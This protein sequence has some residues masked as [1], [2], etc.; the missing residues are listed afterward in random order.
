VNVLGRVATY[1]P[2]LSEHT[3]KTVQATL[4][5]ILLAI[6]IFVCAGFAGAKLGTSLGEP[7]YRELEPAQATTASLAPAQ[8]VQKP[9]ELDQALNTPHNEWSN[10]KVGSGQSYIAFADPKSVDVVFEKIDAFKL[11]HP[12]LKVTSS[13]PIPERVVAEENGDTYVFWVRG[14]WINHEPKEE[15]K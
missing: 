12:E 10:V 9:S 4:G 2:A 15:A 11:E 13:I 7:A 6:A 8:P 3:E 1:S 14:V 5:K